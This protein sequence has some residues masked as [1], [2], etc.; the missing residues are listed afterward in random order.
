MLRL[1]LLLFFLPFFCIAQIP[2]PKPGTYVNDYTNSLTS[3]ETQAL[4]EQILQLEK[5]TTV[6]VA[7]LLVKNLP[8]GMSIEDYAKRKSFKNKS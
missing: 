1:F 7:I 4:N 5:Q 8:A 2:K 6:Q 3:E